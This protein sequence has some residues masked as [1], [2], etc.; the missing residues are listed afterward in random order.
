[1]LSLFL[2][3][4]FV[5]KVQTKQSAKDTK[6]ENQKILKQN[7]TKVRLISDI[8]LAF[9]SASFFVYPKHDLD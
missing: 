2:A 3:H 8:E 9:V 5:Q 1:M 6:N 4:S 7:T